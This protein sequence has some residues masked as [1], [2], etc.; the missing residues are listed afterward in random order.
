MVLLAPR[1]STHRHKSLSRINPI[2]ATDGSLHRICE[3]SE[4]S[5]ELDSQWSVGE[6]K[7]G[8]RD[9]TTPDAGGKSVSE[10]SQVTYTSKNPLRNHT[11][12]TRNTLFVWLRTIGLGRIVL[13]SSS[14]GVTCLLTNMIRGNL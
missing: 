3:T 11:V 8:K 5:C 13:S 7:T 9:K 1:S 2:C 14:G 12:I 10:K 6:G 4:T